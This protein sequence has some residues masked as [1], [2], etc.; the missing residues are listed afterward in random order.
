MAFSSTCTQRP[1]AVGNRRRSFGTFDCSS[2]TG[3]D[4]DTKL[5]R[6]ETIS[7]TLKSSAVVANAPVVNED[8]PVAGSAVTIVTDSGATGYWEA[9]GY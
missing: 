6:C 3:G 4:I 7:L 8:L 5:T 2:A 1:T 9:W